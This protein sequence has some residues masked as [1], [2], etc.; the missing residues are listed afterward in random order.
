MHHSN[1]QLLGILLP[2]SPAPAPI[3]RRYNCEYLKRPGEVT[4][5]DAAICKSDALAPS[6]P[7]R[8]QLVRPGVIFEFQGKHDVDG[9]LI[10]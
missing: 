4:F 10:A 9:S 1:L 3:A 5:L 2:Y 7:S 8:G 6:L